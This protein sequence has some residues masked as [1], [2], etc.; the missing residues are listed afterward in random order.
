[1]A[2]GKNIILLSLF[3]S[4]A[5]IGCVKDPQDIPGGLTADPS[6]GLK[7]TLDGQPLSIDAGKGGWT[8]QPVVEDA[9]STVVYTSIFSLNEC[10]ENCKSSLEFRFYRAEPSSGN[11]ETDFLQ[12]IKTGSKEFIL[13]PAERD[14]FE[15]TL[16]A[17]SGL[18]MSGY[19]Y[20]ENLSDPDYSY[21]SEYKDVVGYGEFLNVC[22]QSLA[23]TGCQYSQCIYFN[24]ATLVPCLNS[25]QAKLEDARTVSVSIRPESG[26]PPYKT[27]WFNGSTSQSIIL[28]IQDVAVDLYVGVTVTDAL[29][30][31]SEL[32]QKIRVQ[33]S[34]VDACYFPISLVSVPVPNTSSSVTS[35][36]VEI[37]YIDDSGVEWSSTSGM[38][39]S[40]SELLINDVQFFGSSPMNQPSYKT[41]LN[42]SVTLFNAAGDSKVLE[43]QDVSLA[44][45][46]R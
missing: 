46:H 4:L 36:K 24:P 25:I 19:S 40:T 42:T 35:G 44:L 8:V 14:S 18:F 41:Q 5:W 10:L 13:S 17:H 31:R 33:D 11:D 9:N 6:F 38:Q 2:I 23:Y 37:I 26:T 43:L 34:I 16:N 39:P 45:S 28:Q 21:Q 3:I 1:M 7:G 32:S 27:E 29:G 15:I 20:W 12:T 30:N 22:F